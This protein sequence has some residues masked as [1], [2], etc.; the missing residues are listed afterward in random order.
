M[1]IMIKL[2]G[3]G[4]R[5]RWCAVLLLALPAGGVRSADWTITPTLTTRESYTDN[6]FLAPPGQARSESTSELSP[7]LSVTATGPRLTL[8]LDYSLQ[9]IN[10]RREPDRRNQQLDANS[11]AT[12]LDGWLFLDARAAITQQNISAF[13]PQLSQPEQITGNSDT[14]HA[15]TIA[16][17]L[18]HYFHGL[19]TA[20]LRYTVDKVTSGQLLSVRNRDTNLGLTG[21]NGGH[22]WNWDLSS[23]R[24]EI[25]DSALAPVTMTSS[26][27]TLSFPIDSRLSFITVGGAE[28]NDYHSADANTQ[29]RFW[30]VGLNWTPSPRTSVAA[31]VGH[32][33][34][35]NTQSLNAQYRMRSMFWQLSYADTISTTQAQILALAPNDVGNFL[36][37][38]WAGSIPDAAQR[39]QTINAF[40]QLSKLLGPGAGNVSYFSHQ[41]Y[42]Q[43]QWNVATVYSSPKSAFALGFTSSGR[44]A[45]TSSGL[46]SVLLGPSQVGLDDRTRQNTANAGWS[47][48]MAPRNNLS[49][50]A[51]VGDVESISTGRRDRNSVLSL[52]L[53]RQLRPKVSALIELHHNRHGSNAGG[54]YREN[55][56]SA[57]LVVQ[58]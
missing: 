57:A 18:R 45:Q 55:G 32:H 47:W 40:L 43:K 7:G 11:H 16:P 24:Q 49:L 2:P 14:V 54:D 50:T 58:F 4:G 34:Y 30:S 53:S 5:G 1:V 21:D 22:G 23:D 44:T 48:R 27:L 3:P 35:G 41:Y 51:S 31:S 19:A 46:D 42:L 8:H 15:S 29:G 17:L 36:Y 9:Q 20:Q 38:L 39:I 26:A 12:L 28:K 33:F 25:A 13:G 56:A 10:Y 6:L 37:Q 52:S